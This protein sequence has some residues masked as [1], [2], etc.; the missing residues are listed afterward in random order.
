MALKLSSAVR[1]CLREKGDARQ[2]D[3]QFRAHRLGEVRVRG[4]RSA[5]AS[6]Q[7]RLASLFTI[8]RIAYPRRPE[9]CRQANACCYMPTSK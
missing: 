1:C 2:F 3:V 7:G 5:E 4:V 6:S 8:N 9:A